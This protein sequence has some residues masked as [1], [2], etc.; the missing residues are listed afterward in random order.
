MKKEEREVPDVFSLNVP[1]YYYETAQLL[2]N[3][4]KDEF[5]NFNETKSVVEDLFQLRKEK[6]IRI[7]KKVD[8]E[9]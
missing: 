2:F 4:C 1:Y 6:L 3:E 9:D 8:P 5:S 7:M